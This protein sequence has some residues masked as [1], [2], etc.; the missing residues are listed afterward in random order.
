MARTTDGGRARSTAW[1]DLVNERRA[2]QCAIH[3]SEDGD[4]N[5]LAQSSDLI[6]DDEGGAFFAMVKIISEPIKSQNALEKHKIRFTTAFEGREVLAQIASCHR[7]F[8]DLL[9]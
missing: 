8:K 4:S 6:G 1:K 7:S 9:V 5:T 2:H 3:M